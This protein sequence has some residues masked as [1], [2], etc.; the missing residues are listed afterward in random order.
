MKF[1]VTYL[2][3][4]IL[5]FGITTSPIWA[6]NRALSLDGDGDWVEI[7]N[8]PA[9][10]PQQI[11][12]EA[13][14]K[15][16]VIISERADYAQDIL[17]K[18]NDQTPGAYYLRQCREGFAFSIG[19]Y[20][21]ENSVETGPDFS[22][23]TKHWYHIAGAY[24]GTIMRLF[25]DGQLIES[26][27][28]G[29]VTVGNSSP[30]LIGREL[31]TAFPYF[32][33]GQIDE[34]RIWDIARTQEQIQSTMNTTL[35]G[36]EE[37]LVGY[38]NFDDGTAKD[39]S[40]NG[41]DG[42]LHGD[43]QIVEEELPDEFIHKGIN[44]IVLEDK[45]ANP[46]DQFTT[47]ISIR[48]AEELH[49]FAFDLTFDPEVL[50]AVSVKEGPFLNRDGADA[51]SWQTPTIDNKNGV[52][53]NIRCSRS[54]KEGV[55]DAG[56]LAI[57]TFEA[58]EMGGTDLT[59]KNLHLLS[60][61]GEEMKARVRQ[62]KVDVYPHGSI[63]G[64]VNDSVSEKPIKGAKVE[65]YKNNFTFGVW[66]YSADDGTYTING[67]PVGDFDVTASQNDYISETISNVHVEQG[68]NTKDIDIKMTVW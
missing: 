67:V 48:L 19:R 3:I 64:V 62:G 33:N 26:K 39:L 7:P 41:N 56:V 8:S 22:A 68:K 50:R 55:R 10:N 51:T 25:I 29:A 57:V 43:A 16:D 65:V 37:G 54:G 35:T 1:V 28:V 36:Q 60:L 47:S 17:N 61:T 24:D 12:I 21:E 46:G 6:V 5:T 53:S 18:P 34:V 4:L 13:W 11:T 59:F 63:S 49:G 42:S 31:L 66:T 30:L 15:F 9:L 38:W 27:E 14:V 32:V 2:S 45:I 20:Y 40:P 58:I 44:A 52:I 23:E